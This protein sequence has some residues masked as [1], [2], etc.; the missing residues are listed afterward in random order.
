MGAQNQ[1]IDA[2]RTIY[3]PDLPVNIHDLWLTCDRGVDAGTG[4][5]QIRLTDSPGCPIAQ[6]FPGA[7]ECALRGFPGIREVHVERVGDTPWDRPRRSGA[8]HL[9]P[10]M[11]GWSGCRYV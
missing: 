8:A 3:D 10:R 2:L 7:V 6:S 9:K 5:V 11:S 1:R 4:S